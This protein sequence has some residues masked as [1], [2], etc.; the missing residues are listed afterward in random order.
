[1]GRDAEDKE[2]Y[3]DN[4]RDLFE[5]F[6]EARQW[7]GFDVIKLNRWIKNFAEL[8]DGTYY[9]CKILNC[10]IGYSENDIAQMLNEGICKIMHKE[11]ILPFL[12]EKEFSILESELDY[13]VENAL[14]KTLFA[15]LLAFGAPGESA[16][17]M[18]RVLTQKV[19]PPLKNRMFIS[20]VPEDYICTTLILVDDCIGSGE[21]FSEFWETAQ[22]GNG[23]LLRKW[24][25]EKN[26]HVYYL[27]LVAYDK[28]LDKLRVKYRDITIISIEEISDKHG[29][30]NI[31]N[32]VW[33]DKQD[34]DAAI[35]NIQEL[36]KDRGINMRGYNK[37]DFGVILHNSIPDWS[38]PI[39]HKEKNDWRLL[40]E[41][42]DSND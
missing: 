11:A 1:M 34:L 28:T 27:C 23:K 29:I 26:I 17:A 36:I 37:L 9:A 30:F 32:G 31:N 14:N 20:D 7:T 41:R 8:E 21:Q 24:C 3:I 42:K 2:Y 13:F 16:D 22:I 35:C 15:P 33:D 10:I 18:M 19:K 25:E 5:F 12:V 4:S 40:V 39:L 38:L 6:I